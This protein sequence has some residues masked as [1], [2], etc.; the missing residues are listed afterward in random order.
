MSTF[1]S[2]TPEEL[3]NDSRTNLSKVRLIYCMKFKNFIYLQPDKPNM[4]WMLE[5]TLEQY[6]NDFGGRKII[7]G[8]EILEKYGK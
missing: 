2:K 4:S 1:K 6:E 5:L 7:D 8:S 3:I